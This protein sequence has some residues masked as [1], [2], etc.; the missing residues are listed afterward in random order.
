MKRPRIRQRELSRYGTVVAVVVFAIAAALILLR[1]LETPVEYVD[2]LQPF[3]GSGCCTVADGHSVSQSFVAGSDGLDRVHVYVASVPAESRGRVRFTLSE[4][5][6]GTVLRSA[7]TP[8]AELEAGAYYSFAFPAVRAS[9]GRAYRFTLQGDG[10][11]P[12]RPITFG[13]MPWNVYPSGALAAGEA[14]VP[15]SLTFKVGYRTSLVDGYLDRLS[16][17]KP[18]I[19]RYPVTYVL[20]AVAYVGICLA[21][22]VRGIQLARRASKEAPS[23]SNQTP[24]LPRDG[25]F[26]IVI[27]LAVVQGLAYVSV[28]PPWS[29]PDEPQHFAYVKK[30]V[31]GPDSS[32]DGYARIERQIMTSMIQQRWFATNQIDPPARQPVVFDDFPFFHLTRIPEGYQPSGYYLLAALILERVGHRSIEGQLY[33]VR[34]V[35]VVLG[36]VVVGI[37]YVTARLVFVDDR[38]MPLVVAAT[39]ALV[40]QRAFIAS[41][42]NNDNLAILA[43]SLVFLV[44]ISLIASGVSIL[45]L[46]AL[47]CGL[48][49]VANSKATAFAVL[50][51][52]VAVGVGAALV[53][54]ARRWSRT[55]AFAVAAGGLAVAI[56]AISQSF[57][58]CG[59][60]MWNAYGDM[61]CPRVAAPG[62]AGQFAL[63]VTDNSTSLRA[64]LSQQ[65]TGDALHRLRG[66]TVTFGAW[67][68]TES[69]VQSA[70]AQVYD[71]RTSYTLGFTAGPEWTFHARSILI[72]RDALALQ[73]NLGATNSVVRTIGEVFYSGIVLVDG[74]LSRAGA[75]S[76]VNGTNVTWDRKQFTN[77]V[78]NANGET[79]TYQPITV[80]RDGLKRTGGLSALTAAQTLVNRARLQPESLQTYTAYTSI[81]INSFWGQFGWMNVPLPDELYSALQCLTLVS[82]VAAAWFVVDRRHRSTN[83]AASIR[84][85]AVGLS[86]LMVLSGFTMA[87]FRD[88][89][90]AGQSQ[91]RYAL[92]VVVPFA[93]VFC[94]GI[95]RACP[96]HA[97]SWPPVALVAALVALDAVGLAAAIAPL[98]NLWKG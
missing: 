71:G 22:V 79:A 92:P 63:R 38:L 41:G 13:A 53:S 65:L 64:V 24:P 17:G 40:P 52:V 73:V 68:R 58:P 6:S 20:L 96:P 57:Y 89:P 87:F 76:I 4:A 62:P 21:V 43:A 55:A 80:L 54:I 31:D 94:S 46:L 82:L 15:G 14:T 10:I 34:L 39:V 12:E 18:S 48:F 72:P 95:R 19:W 59:A 97:R 66:H 30:L 8:A 29:V 35:S 61:P 74:D 49:L 56:V 60:A 88:V 7:S 3:R 1:V 78:V 47:A 44:L 93:V 23:G 9:K 69:G 27:A 26:A 37:A 16:E 51:G 90:P 67:V 32:A 70:Y 83:C 11:A 28:V 2:D 85:Q 86:M 36:I 45:R 84:W 98:T 81:L 42:V 50:P 25:V 33:V 91:G 75:P 5:Q 77:A